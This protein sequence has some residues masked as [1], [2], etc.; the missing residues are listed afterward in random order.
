MTLARLFLVDLS[1]TLFASLCVVIYLHRHLK[2]ILTDL[3]GTPE[4][5]ASGPHSPS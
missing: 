1:L 5:A 2:I 3:C 4:R